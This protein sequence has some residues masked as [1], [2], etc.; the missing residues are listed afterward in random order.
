MFTR[1]FYLVI[2]CA[3]GLLLASLG[4]AASPTTAP[5]TTT[6]TTTTPTTQPSNSFAT[7]NFGIDQRTPKEQ[8]ELLTQLGYQ[9]ITTGIIGTGGGVEILRGYA[10]VPAIQ[11]GK[12][13][14]YGILWWAKAAEGYDPKWLD[15]MLVQAARMNAPL[16]V[17]VDGKHLQ[18]LDATLKLLT[19]IAT[20]CAQHKVQ[21]VLYPHAG[22][23][24]QSTEEALDILKQLNRPEVKIS[25]HLCHELKAGNAA[26]L[27]EIV[28]KAAPQL[29]LVSISG[30]KTKAINNPGWADSIMP[31]D[32]GD[33]D[34]APLVQA[35]H[36]AHYQ[37]PIVL[38]TYGITEKPEDHLARSIA[39]WNTFL[40]NLPPSKE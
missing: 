14:L 31:L 25:L 27:P 32:E 7:F 17:V 26:R 21:L 13:K 37:G 8:V 35:L 39:W 5:A 22:C 36:K 40:K 11:S 24:F 20:Q 10:A 33:F 15:E 23:V 38:H 29:A 3:A 6:T 9:G 12:F 19:S 18:E 34:L 30:A 1:Q 28:A 4:Y 2:L 16:W